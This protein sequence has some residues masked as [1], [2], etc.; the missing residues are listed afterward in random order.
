[1]CD[2]RYTYGQ[3][4]RGRAD[5]SVSVQPYKYDRSNYG[6]KLINVE[7]SGPL[8]AN[9]TIS[10]TAYFKGYYFDIVI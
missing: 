7:V 2:F 9:C 3:P 6:S 4:V 10:F 1:M 8:A 5:I